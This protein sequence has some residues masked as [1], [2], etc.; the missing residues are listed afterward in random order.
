VQVVL[1][2]KGN[3]LALRNHIYISV[4]RGE[5]I[6]QALKKSKLEYQMQLNA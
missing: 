3:K 4:S 5:I 2:K 1:D 6:E